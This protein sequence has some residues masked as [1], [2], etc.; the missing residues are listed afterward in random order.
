[1]S[2]VRQAFAAFT[3]LPHA[4]TL[5]WRA[6]GR[7]TM[8]WFA[9]LLV[10]GVLPVATVY[11]TRDLV[12]RLV[13]F[14]GGDLHSI[15]LLVVLLAA[16]LLAAQAL[17]GLSGWVRAAQ[18]ELVQDYIADLIHT[19]AAAL[20]LS[21]YD[22]PAYYDM[23]HRAR[24]DALHRPIALLESLGAIMQ[25]SITLVAMAGALFQFGGWVPLALIASTAPALAVTFYYTLQEHQWRMRTTT[26]QRRVSYYDWILTFREA[27]AE[28]RLFALG[29]HFRQAYQTLRARLREERLHLI[30]TQAL[31]D[32]L[33]GVL[34]L[35]VMGGVLALMVSRALQAQ[36]T[37]GDL[38]LLYQA[39]S[40]GQ[41]L[42]R[43]LLGNASQLYANS[44]FLENLFEFLALESQVREPASP[45]PA[46]LRQS[47]RFEDVSFCYPGSSH[48]ALE[49]FDLTL[50]AGQIVAIVGANGAGKSTLIKLL[51]RF[52]NPTEGRILFDGT[53]VRDLSLEALH[54]LITVLFQEPV[55]YHETVAHNIA[56]GDWAAAPDEARIHAAAEAAGAEAIIAHLP[57]GY[58][59]VL[60]KWFGGAELSVGEWQ[61]IALARA[62]LRRSPLIVLDEPTSAMDSWAEADWMARFR[63][64]VA[65]RTALMITH[66]FTT[67]LKAD[68]IYVMAE[69]HLIESGT[70]A[71][72]LAQN[73]H[74]ARSWNTQMQEAREAQEDGWTQR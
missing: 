44:L 34:G 60:G 70:H 51:C 53:D 18:S 2:K 11:L 8:A 39:F 54:G 72:L 27:A 42:M 71:D 41:A 38:A 56:Y 30:R 22:A 19:Q 14:T 28:L 32:L 5:V 73:G 66:R 9:L 47:I 35:A 37:L 48:K 21:F 20:D 26:Q 64:L 10:Q 52:Y 6:A 7:W 45:Q 67:A 16:L 1:L 46:A 69:G 3:Y 43:T 74:Y 24:V 12:N 29:G 58:E 63:T 59:E 61:R 65:G 25:N 36:I 31:A 49:H 50:P 33:A 40:Q 15:L 55:R 23:L 17:S 68:M 13:G 4:L 62:F 57:A